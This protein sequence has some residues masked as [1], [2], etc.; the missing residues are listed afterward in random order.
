MINDNYKL[1]NY[2]RPIL[3]TPDGS[4]KILLHSCCSPCAGEVM[5]A[6]VASKIDVT[7]FFYN[8]NI[9]P[10][11]E[12]IIRKDENKRY[13]DKLKMPFIDSDYDKD[14]WFKLSRGMEKEPERGKRCTMCF[15][16][17]FFKTAQYASNNGFSLIS[18]TL[19]ISKWTD[20]S[21]INKS[22][23]KA[24]SF[25]KNII[26][27]DFNW[28]KKGGSY[29]MLEISKRENFYQQEYCGCA[30]SFRD[31]NNWRIKNG[32]SKIKIGLKFYSD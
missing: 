16:M 1:K 21:Q 23:E 17:R 30:Y 29:R 9:H 4:N 7:I 10:E 20:M 11:K 14:N 24:A 31:T 27:W 5:E 25:F 2:E 32:K 26:Y 28:R 3:K 12:Y 19:G 18:S 13:A 8:P 6:L 15:D 22:G